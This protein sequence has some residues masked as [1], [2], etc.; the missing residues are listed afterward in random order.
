MAGVSASI[1]VEGT[2][3][4]AAELGYN[5]LFVTDA[6]EDTVPASQNNSIVN[7]FPCLGELATTEELSEKM[8]KC[9]CS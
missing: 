6:M 3:R 2:A 4:A 5:I 7:I 9:N 1:G 8:N